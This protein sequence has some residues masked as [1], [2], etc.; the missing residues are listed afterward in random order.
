MKKIVGFMMLVLSLH[1]STLRGSIQV[2]ANTFDSLSN[3]IADPGTPDG[4]V[5]IESGQLKL[6]GKRFHYKGAF[7]SIPNSQFNNPYTGRLV[8]LPGK[9]SWAFN[10]SNMNAPGGGVNNEFGV[11]L[12]SNKPNPND[13]DQYSYVLSG[14]G[15]V[16]DRM[17]LLR[18]THTLSPYGNNSKTLIDIPSEEGLSPLPEKG[19]FRIEFTPALGIWEVYA[20][21]GDHYVDPMGVT[22][23]LGTA[24]DSTYVNDY[25]PYFTIEGE[26]DGAVFFDNLI[27][28]VIPEPTTLS[29]LLVGTLGLMRRRRR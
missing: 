16:G 4:S 22:Q 28:T 13:S 19:S 9:I 15:Y 24:F 7:V 29:L 26:N 5:S 2:Y 6:V 27:I 12:V 25:L 20:F 1:P 3:V 10:L 8:D 23:R 18:A 14:G 21:Y 11:H 17:T